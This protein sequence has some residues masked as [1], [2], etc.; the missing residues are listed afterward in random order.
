[1]AS[2]SERDIFFTR[3][4]IPHL[5]PCENTRNMLKTTITCTCSVHGVETRPPAFWPSFPGCPLFPGGSN[6]YPANFHSDLKLV[7]VIDY[8]WL[9]TVY[10]NI[11]Q[12]RGSNRK[13]TAKPVNGPQSK[14]LPRPS[15]RQ[16]QPS[17]DK[18]QVLFS[19]LSAKY[20][21]II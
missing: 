14:N 20:Q 19:V 15:A 17:A 3:P 8:S 12:L 18:I 6:P 4:P 1:M 2:D 13:Y 10:G 7:T 9:F 5:T 16:P 11:F 21:L